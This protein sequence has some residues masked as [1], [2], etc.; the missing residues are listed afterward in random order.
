MAAQSSLIGSVRTLVISDLHLGTSRR[1]GRAAPRAA[2]GDAAASTSAP[3]ASSAWSCSATRSR[4]ATGPLRAALAVAEPV[5][6]ALGA[7][8]G[9]DGL[10]VLVAGQPRP[11]ARR[12]V[13][14]GPRRG[15]DAVAAGPRGAP[16]ARGVVGARAPRGGRAAGAPRR[17]PPGDLA[18]GGRLRPHGHYL[19]R[20][21]TVPTFERLAARAHDPHRRARCPTR[22]RRATSRP[23]WRRSTPGCTPWRR[24][25]AA[26]PGRRPPERLDARPG[27]CSAGD[28]RGTPAARPRAVGA[29][30]ARRRRARTS[31]AWARCA[32]ASPARTLR[33]AGLAAIAEVV[34]RL[35][36][37]AD[38]VLFGHTHRAGPLPA[39]DHRGV[40]RRRHG[41]R[42][43][44]AG[45]WIDEPVFAPPGPR[46]ALLGRPARSSS[47]PSPA[48]RRGSCA[49]RPSS[50]PPT[51]RR[52]RAR[53]ARA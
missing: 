2:A 7:A 20:F 35:G 43:H 31:P 8:L 42:L 29:L 52:R 46:G 27:R 51:R 13:A 53:P 25:A 16:G 47:T 39:D 18:A 6:A 23:R 3:P 38:H 19:D 32:R 28:G 49:W 44:N 5:L 1:A 14:R 41:G 9:P 26:A 15:R 48:R 34:R 30:P 10:I 24:R 22:R 33:R 37:E 36:I 45:G 12:A 40:A 17:R 50:A 21:M 4:C 11:P